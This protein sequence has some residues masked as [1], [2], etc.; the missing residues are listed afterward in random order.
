M[1]DKKMSI[2]SLQ[3][4]TQEI[5]TERTANVSQLTE[6]KN[7]LEETI[8]QISSTVD[9]ITLVTHMEPTHI[10]LSLSHDL[11]FSNHFL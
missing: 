10:S 8:Q 3:N 4:Q 2:D 11:L 9:N 1:T 5:D 6:T 7:K